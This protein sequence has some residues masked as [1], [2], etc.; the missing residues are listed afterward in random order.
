MKKY[1]LILF[2]MLLSVIW[3]SSVTYGADRILQTSVKLKTPK[4]TTRGDETLDAVNVS[5]W[6]PD[7]VK[8]L[9]GVI[10][11]PFYVNLVERKD[12][13]QVARLWEFGLIGANFFGVKNDDYDALLDAMNEFAEKSGH[14][15]IEH[16]PMV[17]Q[18]GRGANISF[19]NERIVLNK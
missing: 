19:D 8:V 16:L 1:I 13:H 2:A 17:F 9:R 11:N 14:R 18:P 3:A 15:E 6:I 7:G 4:T 10:V 12:Y 5:I